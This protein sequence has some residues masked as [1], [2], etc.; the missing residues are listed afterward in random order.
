MKSKMQIKV[1]PVKCAKCQD[2]KN[3][4]CMKCYRALEDKKEDITFTAMVFK[5][6][7]QNLEDQ[8]DEIRQKLNDFWKM[9]SK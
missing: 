3:Y 4:V 9:D 7:I 8:L 6:Y 2:G 1:K 5:N